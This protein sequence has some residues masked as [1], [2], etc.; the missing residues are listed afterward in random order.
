[1]ASYIGD[2]QNQFLTCRYA[3]FSSSG[4]MLGYLLSGKPDDVFTSISEK[5]GCTLRS[6]AEHAARPNR[7]SQHKR[8]VPAGKPYPTEFDCYHIILEY[9]DLSRAV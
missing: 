3:P 8:T 2:V 7:V 4:A 9:P 5:L 6:V 1:V